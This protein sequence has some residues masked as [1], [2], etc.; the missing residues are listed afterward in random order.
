MKKKLKI[1]S[2]ILTIIIISTVILSGCVVKSTK[3]GKEGGTSNATAKTGEPAAQDKEETTGFEKRLEITWLIAYDASAYKEGS[4]VEKELE[5]KFN[6]DLKVVPINSMD[7]E[8]FYATIASGTIPDVI[9]R[10]DSRKLYS[11][12]IVRAI[13]K[14]MIKQYMP[15]T[16]KVIDELGGKAA[17]ESF[18]SYE[19]GKLFAVP[20][21]A[22]N[23]AAKLVLAARKDWMNNLGITALPKT[24]DEIYDL[25]K[26]FTFND[27]DKDGKNNT[28]GLGGAGMHPNPLF[29]QFQTI[30]G[31]YGVHPQYWVEEDGKVVF[32]AVANGYK[33]ALRTLS[34]WYKNGVI[35]YEFITNTN[36]DYMNKVASGMLGMYEG[37]PTYFDTGFYPTL[38]PAMIKEKNPQA[39]FVFLDPP[40]G[41]Q[42]KSGAISYGVVGSWG[43]MYSVKASEEKVI[44]A[45]QIGEALNTDINLFKLTFAGIEGEHYDVVGDQCVIRKGIVEA[46]HGIK[47]FR[48]GSYLTMD[49]VKTFLSK[50]AI[51]LVMSTINHPLMRSIVDSGRLITLNKDK[52]NTAEMDKLVKE[53]YFNAITGKVDVNSEW[54][55]YVKKW[56]DFG[57]KILTEEAQKAPRLDK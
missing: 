37:H 8:K 45:M 38:P 11:D 5:D 40:K 33:E 28:Y 36:A 13:S 57:G 14:D 21:I 50:D 41:P 30:F 3:D 47:M 49:V 52:V 16:Y 18:T 19:D 22:A 15:T 53:F 39:E 10:W 46:E 25:A 6:V 27:P 48:T 31:G 34:N 17:W 55:N 20:Q 2:L 9:V 54:D 1:F 32:G 29:W 23:G 4:K 42:G 7:N 43:M 12:G 26:A 51:N 35:D 56:M 44:R 24:I